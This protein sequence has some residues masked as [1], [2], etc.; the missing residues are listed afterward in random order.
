[1]TADSRS[2]VPC[3]RYTSARE[4]IGQRAHGSQRGRWQERA[5]G[6]FAPC[7]HQ[8]QCVGLLA[9][10]GPRLD[11]PAD[12][13]IGCFA[14]RDAVCIEVLDDEG[15]RRAAWSVRSTPGADK[16]P[17]AARIH[18]HGHEDLE[19]LGCG[20]ARPAR[21]WLGCV[22]TDRNARTGSKRADDITGCAGP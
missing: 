14:R 9:E 18:A 7:R 6:A 1:M 2:D 17:D 21:R 3:A 10:H 19:A 16:L 11:A 13:G 22:P 8:A 4:L 12:E 5:I 15:E 20:I